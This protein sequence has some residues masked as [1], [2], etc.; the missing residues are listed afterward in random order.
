MSCFSQ[1]IGCHWFHE[2][3]NKRFL[4]PKNNNIPIY[5]LKALLYEYI[6][7]GAPCLAIRLFL[8]TVFSNRQITKTRSVRYYIY[9]IHLNHFIVSPNT[10]ILT[11]KWYGVKDTKVT[12]VTDG[13]TAPY[14]MKEHAN[15]DFRFFFVTC[16]PNGVYKM[17]FDVFNFNMIL[18]I[19]QHPRVSFRKTKIN[20]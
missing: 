8:C 4:A 18:L 15:L 14:D 16:A 9:S 13:G 12:R 11:E 1:F 19:I 2:G 10:L 20:Q 17:T 5:W 7:T 6:I 3:S